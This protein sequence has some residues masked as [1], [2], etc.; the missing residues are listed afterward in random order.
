MKC[1]RRCYLKRKFGITP[2]QY[3]LMFTMQNGYCAICNIHQSKL[4]YRLA[5]D[6]CHTTGKV[7]GLL[8]SACNKALGVFNDSITTLNVAIKYLEKTPL[9]TEKSFDY[10][11]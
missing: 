1:N 7:R 8:C 4:K 3:D 2:E 10:S 11:I 6:H 5:V 9:I